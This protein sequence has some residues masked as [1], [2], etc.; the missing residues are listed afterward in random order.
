ML[1]KKII[2]S[3]GITTVLKLIYW[4]YLEM[5]ARTMAEMPQVKHQARMKADKYNPF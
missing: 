3:L 4:L 1:A 2:N 5:D